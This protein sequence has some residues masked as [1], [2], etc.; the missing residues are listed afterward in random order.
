MRPSEHKQVRA[1]AARDVPVECQGRR[2]AT[3]GV[4]G[5]DAGGVDAMMCIEQRLMTVLGQ[6]HNAKN[7]RKGSRGDDSAG[8]VCRGSSE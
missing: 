1:I 6:L 4:A 3:E 8:A 5:V 2:V 7:A